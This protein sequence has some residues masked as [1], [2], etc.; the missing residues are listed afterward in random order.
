MRAMLGDDFEAAAKARDAADL[1]AALE[2]A[3]VPC[4]LVNFEDALPRFFDDPAT[5]AMTRVS[6]LPQPLYRLVAQPGASWPFG[7]IPVPFMPCCPP[8]GARRAAI[9]PK[10]GYSDDE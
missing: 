3:G 7:D 5:R 9:H 6:V 1:L 2:A 4:D 10:L 8:W